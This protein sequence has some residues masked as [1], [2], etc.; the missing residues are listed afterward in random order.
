MNQLNA[1]CLETPGVRQSVLLSPWVNEPFPPW[2]QIHTSHEVARLTPKRSRR[3]MFNA[4]H[5]PRPTGVDLVRLQ[6]F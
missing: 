5:V 4:T 2:D 6:S 3:S 1:E